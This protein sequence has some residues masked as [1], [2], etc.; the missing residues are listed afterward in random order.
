[1]DKTT[2]RLADFALAS[3]FAELD[4]RTVHE[5][6][7]R[8]IDAL[9]CAIGAYDEPLSE[10]ARAAASRS[11]ADPGARIWGSRA[12][13]SPE[14]A[15]FA[16]GVMVRLMDISDTFLGKARG[17][18][19]DVLSGIFAVA[20]SVHADGAAVI[21]ASVLA[22]DVYCSLCDA[23]DWNSNGWD[24]PVYAVLATAVGAGKLLGLTREQM[25][26]AIAL[27]LAPNMAMAQTRRGPLSSWKG[28]AG[29]NGTR[30]GV[31]AAQLARDG[32]T[33]PTAI[34]EG[35]GGLFELVGSFD[36]D[37]A[38][39]GHMIGRTHI[40]QLPVCYHGQSSVQAA[41]ALR[42]RVAA[43][44]VSAIRIDTYRTA[45]DMM[46]NDPS[47]WAPR[48]HETADHS[49]PYTVA[50]ALL[51]GKV[52]PASFA[53]ERFTDPAVVGLMNRTEVHEDPALTAAFPE[54]SPGRV[55]VT[56]VGGEKLIG[57][58]AYPDGHALNPI[59]DAA[60]E[61]KFRGM[62][63]SHACA[64]RCEQILER[65][66]RFETLADVGGGALALF[67]P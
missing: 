28:C 51:D 23:V 53:T 38:A 22:Y 64:A 27:A 61:A 55:T 4:E 11:R 18:P 65:M 45:V 49:L 20:E 67:T 12:T 52:T 24:Q 58:L 35:E 57:E 17:H 47:R 21:D 39:A 62:L 56:T 25:G 41:L 54:A 10:M 13:S 60:L 46:G 15:A 3:R 32:F 9:G 6:K 16:N 44:D 48:T 59:G 36:W 14:M 29:P 8:L 42:S 30:N 63:A 43:R 7:R 37:P 33:G 40:K 2:A 26:E 50:I 19:S 34:F 5:C 1:M 66:W 31:F